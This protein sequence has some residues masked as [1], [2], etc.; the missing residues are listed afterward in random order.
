MPLL[1]GGMVEFSRGCFHPILRNRAQAGELSLGCQAVLFLGRKTPPL[2]FLERKPNYPAIDQTPA[3]YRSTFSRG[4]EGLWLCFE[5]ET[6]SARCLQKALGGVPCR[7]FL[8]HPGEPVSIGDNQPDWF[9]GPLIP[10]QLAGLLSATKH[11]PD[12]HLERTETKGFPQKKKPLF[13]GFFSLP[14]GER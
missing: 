11:A 1:P 14:S 10:L 5:L 13:S 6:S 3:F 4:T 9:C 12:R 8:W 2:F 7:G